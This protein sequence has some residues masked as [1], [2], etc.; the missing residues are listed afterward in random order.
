M[1]MLSGVGTSAVILPSS[2]IQLFI[3]SWKDFS[4]EYS[5]YGHEHGQ[6]TSVHTLIIKLNK[7]ECSKL[8]LI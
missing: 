1:G 4:L 5:G 3:V 2:F 7:D 6:L 8:V